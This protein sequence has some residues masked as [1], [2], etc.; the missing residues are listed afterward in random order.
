MIKYRKGYKYQLAE[1]WTEQTKLTGFSAKTQFIE[2]TPEGVL[3]AFSGYAWDGPS[4]PTVDDE[5]NMEASLGHDVFYQLMRMGLI[6][7]ECRLFADTWFKNKCVEK[8]MPSL[9][10]S[11]WFS[12]LRKFAGWAAD[13][14]RAKKIYKTL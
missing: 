13:P 12:F 7:L 9:K 2:L 14:K 1:D 11:I 3:T 4:G 5:T 10:A 6:P 8:K